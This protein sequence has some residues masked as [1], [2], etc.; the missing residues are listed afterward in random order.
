MRSA[1][2]KP[3]LAADVITPG[4]PLVARQIEIKTSQAVLSP[5]Q[6]SNPKSQKSMW[7]SLE[8]SDP[9]PKALSPSSHIIPLTHVGYSLVPSRSRA[10]FS[11]SLAQ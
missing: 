8:P 11:E 3:A 6:D 5:L 10:L 4:N 7:Y 9:L 2:R 1:V